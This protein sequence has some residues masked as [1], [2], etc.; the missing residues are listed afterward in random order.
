MVA[1]DRRR[2]REAGAGP[3]LAVMVLA[4]LALL[5]A[6]VLTGK[7]AVAGD[8]RSNA[9]HAADASALAGAQAILDGLPDQLA[10]G[11]LRPSDIANL[12]GGGVC[13]QTGRLEASR[14]A[15]K[16]GATL[17]GYC[18]NVFRDEVATDVAM[19]STP[20]TASAVAATSFDAS[21]CTLD[22]D[23]HAPTTAPAAD[24]DDDAPP[25]S[26]APV[27]TSIDCGTGLLRL[28]FSL[29]SA[30]F[31]FVGLAADLADVRPRLV[32]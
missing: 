16:N 19:N 18:Y 14:L 12:M 22:A 26:P 32:R 5:A 1:R 7:F 27:G 15:A 25:P 29:A 28:A 13:V 9:A 2:R 21:S 23:F 20:G 6:V 24:D 31:G 3:V 30:R 11:F 17:T 10:P 8:E 4:V